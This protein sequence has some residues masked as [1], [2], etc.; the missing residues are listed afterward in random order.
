VRNHSNELTLKL[1][2]HGGTRLLNVRFR[3]FDDG[4]GY[5]YEFP[6][7]A[8]W[9]SAVV[10]REQTE[11]RMPY[12]HNAWFIPATDP[13]Y[14]SLYT[15]LPLNRLDTVRTPLTMESADGHYLAIHEA[16]LTDYPKMNLVVTDGTTLRAQLVPWANG[17]A[18]YID[19]PF[20]TPWRT[21]IVGNTPGDLVTSRLMLNLNEP[22][23]LADT[24]WI[25][26][27]KYVGIWWEMHLGKGTWY[28]GP[29]HSATTANMKRYIDFAATHGMSGVLA[30]GWNRGW[31]GNWMKQGDKLDFTRPYP[32]FD[33][34]AITDYAAAKGVSLIGHHETAAAT[35]NYE[36]QLDRAFAFYQQYGVHVVKTGYVNRLMDFKE[37][38]DGQ[39]GVRHYRKVI[40]TAAKYQIAIDNHEPVMPTGIERTY[41]NLMTQEGVRGQEHNAW[42]PDGGNP[43]AHTTIV[44]FTRGL[45]GP[46]DFTFGTFNFTN[47]QY[48]GTRV[49]TTLCKQLALYVVIYSPLQM[50]SDLPENYE[51]VK[52][53]DFIRD[54]PTDWETTLVP[55][56]R[57]GQYALFA[58]K[59]RHSDDWYVGAIT[60][61][62]ARTLDLSLAFLDAGATYTAQIYRDGDHADRKENP[63]DFAYEEKVVTA[64]D[65]LHLKLAPGGGCAIR[66]KVR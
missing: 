65:T 10:M 14:E 16:N 58:R 37:A 26:P 43:P 48:P 21:L 63:T 47:E 46:M 51:G 33:I 31:E 44:P 40:E 3:L 27:G 41:P 12:A 13:Y 8:G 22:C 24:S 45:A 19:L 52:A 39:Y 11:F 38:H 55:D 4:I 49:N 64:A 30:E 1:R 66:L 42:S 61:E 7:Q 56:A 15:C 18:A 57:I 32:D 53:F 60:N 54:V 35:R 9:Q 28:A 50:A 2:E 23:R 36:R 6:R 25:K 20:S 59:D 29:K 62:D 5:R 17:V 34:H